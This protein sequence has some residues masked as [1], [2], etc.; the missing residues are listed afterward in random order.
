MSKVNEIAP[1]ALGEWFLYVNV[2]KTERTNTKREIDCVAEK[3]RTTKKLGSLLGDVEDLSRS[4][5]TY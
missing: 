2:D 3:W 5:T 1:A 4:Q